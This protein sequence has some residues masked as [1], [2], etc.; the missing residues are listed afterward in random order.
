MKK[1]YIQI[2][3]YSLLIIS[4]SYTLINKFFIYNMEETKEIDSYKKY[5]TQMSNHDFKDYTYR[6]ENGEN[7]YNLLKKLSKIEN[8]NYM[9]Y[10]EKNK[11]NDFNNIYNNFLNENKELLKD[12]GLS[13]FYRKT[14]YDK[15]DDNLDLLEKKFDEELEKK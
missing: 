4:I 2:I 8:I 11:L 9:R 15:I 6:F 14:I 7:N 1:K 5:I 13:G 3:L 10:E 12:Q